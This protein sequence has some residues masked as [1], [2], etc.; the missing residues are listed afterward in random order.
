MNKMTGTYDGL[1]CLEYYEVDHACNP[2]DPINLWFP[3]WDFEVESLQIGN[4]VYGS[5]DGL[6]I[7]GT[8]NDGHVRFTLNYPGT[9]EQVL[10]VHMLASDHDQD[11]I[12]DVILLDQSQQTT[13]M[14]YVDGVCTGLFIATD[15]VMTRRGVPAIWIESPERSE[16][17]VPAGF[18]HALDVTVEVPVPQDGDLEYPLD[19]DTF[20]ALLKTV[21]DGQ[22]VSQQDVTQSFASSLDPDTGTYTWTAVLDLTAFGDYEL[23]CLVCNEQGCGARQVRFRVA[24]D[25]RTFPGAALSLRATNIRQRPTDCMVPTA[26]FNLIAGFLQAFSFSGTLPSGQE[27]LD[28]GSS[29]YPV[30]IQLPFGLNIGLS[31]YLDSYAN[32]MRLSLPQPYVLDTSGLLPLPNSEC[33][34]TVERVNAY[35]QD[36]D[37]N[38]IDGT[39]E[40]S[41][42]TVAPAPGGSCALP[43]GSTWWDCSVMADLETEP[44]R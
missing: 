8:N 28:A 7:F 15:G 10:D 14:E 19:P 20:S 32:R 13:G 36:I 27:I 26:T 9:Y 16:V 41:Q 12:A 1:I 43:S 35:F 17:I 23:E 24:Q 38:D 37:P 2:M 6:P 21:Q 5:F 31:A 40:V 42:L 44:A 33:L 18:P 3:C 22:V 4:L 34:V 11:G 29:G 30:D 25:V 39:L